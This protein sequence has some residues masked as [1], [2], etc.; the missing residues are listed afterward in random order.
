MQESFNE[1]IFLEH[2]E[3]NFLNKEIGEFKGSLDL[4]N[5]SVYH[6]IEYILN[7]LN[8]EVLTKEIHCDSVFLVD[9]NQFQL[10]DALADDNG[11]YIPYGNKI[12]LFDL[13]QENAS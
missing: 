10:G 2:T 7:N 11:A 5:L 1:E 6:V 4:H 3:S 13:N 8:C 9:L 12:M